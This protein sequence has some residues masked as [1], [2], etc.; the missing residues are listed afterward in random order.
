MFHRLRLRLRPNAQETRVRVI[1]DLEWQ[2]KMLATEYVDQARE[3]RAMLADGEWSPQTVAALEDALET[4]VEGTDRNIG[5]VQACRAEL[6][7]AGQA[8]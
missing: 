6:R 8:V 5:S 1:C 7:R 4:A 2:S 3:I